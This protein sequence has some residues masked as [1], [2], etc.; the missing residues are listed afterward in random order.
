M[1]WGSK[2]NAGHVNTDPFNAGE[3][4]MP[5]DISSSTKAYKKKEREEQREN[6][7]SPVEVE[8][9]KAKRE[10]TAKAPIEPVEVA[11]ELTT[12]DAG[13]TD[14]AKTTVAPPPPPA[15]HTSKSKGAK[16]GFGNTLKRRPILIIMIVIVIFSVASS[17]VSCAVVAIGAIS[18]GMDS[19]FED[20]D[21]YSTFGNEERTP[22][23]AETDDEKAALTALES[24]LNAVAAG[25]DETLRALIVDDF[26]S[27]IESY[28]GKTP[29]AVGLNAD[30]YASWLMSSITYDVDWIYIDDNEATA[31][32]YANSY[33]GYS[34]IND[35]LDALDDGDD[36]QTAFSKMQEDAEL[37]SEMFLAVEMKKSS[38]SW[39]IDE[40]WWGSAD[41]N[42]VFWM[43]T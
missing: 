2:K 25:E 40:S 34:A 1:A 43:L 36:A 30:E 14:P 23:Q 39:H 15:P 3:P 20:S 19:L 17:A 21:S 16:T 26:R 37:G 8:P 33:R 13:P 18:E 31:Y 10:E 28:T 4:T 11:S 27:Q 24:R 6:A 32:F 35:L 42:D 38:G 5:W 9:P 12:S 29:E 7:T 41:E 22:Y